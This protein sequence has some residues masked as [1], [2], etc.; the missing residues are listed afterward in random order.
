MKKLTR[1]F[2]D[3]PTLE[4]AR[5]LI[6]KLFVH[7]R[8]SGVRLAGRIVETE[9]YTMDDPAF[10]PWGVVDPA[11]GL[12][13]PEGRGYDLFG[14]PGTAYVYRVHTYRLLNVVT[15]REGVA[16]CVLLRAAAPLEGLADMARRRPTARRPEH[17]ANGPGKL[18]LAFDVDRRFHTADLTRAPLFFAEAEE[19]RAWPVAV[20]ARI[21][22]RQGIDLRRRF[23]VPGHPCVS[24]GTPS[25]RAAAAKARRRRR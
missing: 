9:A 18:C 17:L 6:G 8:S 24:P 12:V 22:L 23:F 3:R 14:K 10:R 15:E 16:G 21:G 19:A 13:R 7:E 20:S 5:A 11:T 4:V 1:D 2:F 25:D